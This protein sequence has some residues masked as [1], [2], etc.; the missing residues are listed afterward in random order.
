MTL[1][2]NRRK[3]RPSFSKQTPPGSVTL[4]A[5]GGTRPAIPQQ[6]HGSQQDSPQFS[7]RSSKP[8]HAAGAVDGPAGK[9][10]AS[11]RPRASLQAGTVRQW[12]TLALQL[13]CW[14][15]LAAEQRKTTQS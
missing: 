13:T 5:S 12:M 8:Y 10:V 9:P 6:D 15:K 1:R 3:L 11:L 7:D 2:A 14:W 4:K